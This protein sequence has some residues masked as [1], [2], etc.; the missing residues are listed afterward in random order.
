MAG[1]ATL[2]VEYVWPNGRQLVGAR[3]VLVSERYYDVVFRMGTCRDL[4][5]G[6]E[7]TTDF[8]FTYDFSG[9]NP[10]D[11][12]AELASVALL[13][14]VLIDGPD[15][16]FDTFPELTFGCPLGP[17]YCLIM[18]PAGFER[19]QVCSVAAANFRLG[20]G[21]LDSACYGRDDNVGPWA[22]WSHA[23]PEPGTLA[24][25][26]LGLAGLALSRRRLAA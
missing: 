20:G 6:C 18:T 21:D 11:N 15:G 22:I 4:F 5:S 10:A 7:S 24:L 16:P 9:E 2:I 1:A 13:D 23:A 26:G 17:R 25:L 8:F 19:G 12:E 14:Q 3:N